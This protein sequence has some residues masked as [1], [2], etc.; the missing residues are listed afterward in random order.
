LCIFSAG[1]CVFFSFLHNAGS[2]HTAMEVGHMVRDAPALTAVPA[3]HA[4]V[5]VLSVDSYM[6]PR[7]LLSVPQHH[8]R[9]HPA[10]P[11]P[12]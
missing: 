8:G 9:W 10:G 1:P 3:V 6:L 4:T 12:C 2:I 5:S 7:Y 11:V